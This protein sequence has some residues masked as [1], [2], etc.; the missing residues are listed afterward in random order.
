MMLAK[1]AASLMLPQCTISLP[2][3]PIRMKGAQKDAVITVNWSLRQ[4]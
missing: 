4:A 3:W 1:I 2:G